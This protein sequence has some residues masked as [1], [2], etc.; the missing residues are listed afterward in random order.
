MFDADGPGSEDE[1]DATEKV[2]E[3]ADEKAE[4]V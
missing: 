1:G 3:K 2:P 4:K